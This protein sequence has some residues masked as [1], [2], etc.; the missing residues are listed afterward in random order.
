MPNA[1]SK[2]PVSLSL[3][4]YRSANNSSSDVATNCFRLGE[5]IV[6]QDARTH[7]SPHGHGFGG[8]CGG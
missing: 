5:R 6:L 7:L 3:S 4:V 1:L 2:K 8:V